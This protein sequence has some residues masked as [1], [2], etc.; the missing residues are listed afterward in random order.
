M[1]RGSLLAWARLALGGACVATAVVLAAVYVPRAVNGM[2]AGVLA[3]AYITSAQQRVITSGDILGISADLQ[4][5][6]IQL[7]P[8]RSTYALVLPAEMQLAADKY[9]ISALT[10]EVLPTWFQYLLL[11]AEPVSDPTQ[12]HYIV[13]WGC[14]RAFWDP[15]TKWLW[16]NR[17]GQSIGRVLP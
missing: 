14:D 10:Y 11:P 2:N 8:R 16:D 1:S 13:C 7:I 5:K 6:A 4:T 9:G 17:E 3:D 12:A 15:R